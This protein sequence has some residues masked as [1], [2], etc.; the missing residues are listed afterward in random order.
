MLFGLDRAHAQADGEGFAV[1]GLRASWSPFRFRA[2]TRLAFHEAEAF[3]AAPL[4]L[5]LR[6]RTT[7]VS[8][9]LTLEPAT[10]ALDFCQ[11]LSAETLAALAP[12]GAHHLEQSGVWRGAITLDGRRVAVA[13]SG[14]RDHSWGRRSWAAADH[15]RLFTVSFGE[16]LAVHALAVSATGR[17][18]EGGFV[19]RDGRAERITRVQYVTEGKGRAL[20]A[21]EL[22]LTTAAGPPLRLRGRVLRTITVP[23]DVERRPVRHLHG[24]PYRLVL[25]ESFTRYETADRV[26]HGMAEFT[27]RPLPPAG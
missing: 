10:P 27:E 22:R 6:P 14:S 20:R 8:V 12:L 17:L 1:A 4:P 19:W 21:L 7:S 2:T 11:G 5:L 23:V 15:W 16:D 9:D 24:R 3:P 13:G 25:H 26:G 18:V